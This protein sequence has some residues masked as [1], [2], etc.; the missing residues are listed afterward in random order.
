MAGRK[1]TRPRKIRLH[2][3]LEAWRSRAGLNQEELAHRVGVDQ[4]TISKYENHQQ[5]IPSN[6]LMDI[7]EVLQIRPLQI[8]EPPDAASL[9]ALVAGLPESERERIADIVSVLLSKRN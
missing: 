3:Y 8:Y 5:Q 6:T 4:T 2:N 7:A 9:D 1:P